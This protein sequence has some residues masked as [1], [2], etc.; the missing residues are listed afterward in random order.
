MT[1][2]THKIGANIQGCMAARNEPAN[3]PVVEQA[4]Q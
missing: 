4:R 1:I 3:A 2:T